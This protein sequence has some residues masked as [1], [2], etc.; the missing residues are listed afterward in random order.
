MPEL[1]EKVSSVAHLEIAL[2]LHLNNNRNRR[3]VL[4]EGVYLN[5][6]GL[7]S[8]ELTTSGSPF[9]KHKANSVLS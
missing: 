8:N 3:V 6:P 4:T 5:N 2:K 1:R 9:D 7:F